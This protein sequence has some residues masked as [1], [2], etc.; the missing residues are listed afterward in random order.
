MGKL[1]R[2]DIKDSRMS[3]FVLKEEIQKEDTLTEKMLINNDIEGIIN[4]ELRYEDSKK[5]FYYNTK[6]MM[7]VK[8]YLNI[9]VAD[10][11]FLFNVYDGI[12]KSLIKGE[13]YFIK[14]ENYVV[15]PEYLYL[16][17]TDNKIMVCCIPWDKCD[18]QKDILELTSYFLKVTDH[19]DKKAVEFIYGIYDILMNEGFLYDNINQYINS[20]IS[21]K[22]VHLQEEVA[23]VNSGM[24][25]DKKEC[26]IKNNV[27]GLAICGNYKTENMFGGKILPEKIMM[28]CKESSVVYNGTEDGYVVGRSKESDIYIPFM[29]ISRS[30]AMVYQEG[31]GINIIDMGSSNGTYIN[32]KKISAHVTIHCKVND[33]VTF[34]NIKY[35]VIKKEAG[36]T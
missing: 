1:E 11:N 12:L 28:G 15:K 16:N 31:D 36:F 22:E 14:E 18:F 23:H 25:I 21:N 27:Y 17:R 20:F 3:Y 29:Q 26:K 6:G 34:A 35:R 7:S 19:K 2:L 32:G 4:M 33:I 9:K 10:Y 30:H 24:L 13:S 8:D 5:C